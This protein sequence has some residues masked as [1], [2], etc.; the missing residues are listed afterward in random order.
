MERVRIIYAEDNTRFRQ[1]VCQELELLKI[2]ILAQVSN[3]REL[4]ERMSLRPDVVLLDLD[5]PVMDGSEALGHVITRWPGTRVIIVSM[6][7]EEL[8]IDNYLQ[9]GA[10]G[11]I[12]KHVFSGDIHHL[13]T[14]IRKVARGETYV[15][16][17]PLQR[18]K[19][20]DRQKEIVHMI[21]DGYTNKEIAQE[22]G[23]IERSVE[24]QKQ[25]IYNKVGGERAIDFYRYAFSRGLQFL[26]KVHAKR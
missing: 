9:R 7:D 16:P 21:V 5:M 6:H 4:L 13:V 26:G 17:V 24:K 19:F 14:A 11:Y 23:I 8:L 18:E 1:A 22:T 10:S 20:S 3:G 2:D 15:H 12:S 25:K